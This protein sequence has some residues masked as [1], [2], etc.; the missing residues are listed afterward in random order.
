M[1]SYEAINGDITFELDK[2]AKRIKGRTSCELKGSD[3]PAFKLNADFDIEGYE[4]V[5]R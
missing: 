1:C 3:T 4:I 5:L 2:E